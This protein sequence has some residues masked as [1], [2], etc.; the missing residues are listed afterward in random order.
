MTAQA[1]EDGGSGSESDP[2]EDNL[3]E[4]EI[5]KIVPIKVKKRAGV[6]GKDGMSEKKG[7]NGSI[8]KKRT[9]EI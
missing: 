8:V 1:E 4:E 9:E 3:E 7:K 5:A 2:S 6:K